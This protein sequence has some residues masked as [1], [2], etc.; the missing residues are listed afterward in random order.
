MHNKRDMH[1]LAPQFPKSHSLIRPCRATHS[2][3]SI[4]MFAWQ[5]LLG[6]FHSN[7]VVHG[8]PYMISR[9]RVC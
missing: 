9:H 8:M 1:K 3:F 6:T 2:A 7:A 5:F 4:Y